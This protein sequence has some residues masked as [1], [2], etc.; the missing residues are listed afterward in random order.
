MN[1]LIGI[2][3][4]LL[5]FILGVFTRNILIKVIGVRNK[6]KVAEKLLLKKK[7]EKNLKKNMIF[8]IVLKRRTES[9]KRCDI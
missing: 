2:I 9:E 5:G 6:I 4:F 1:F 3:C 8:L 7:R